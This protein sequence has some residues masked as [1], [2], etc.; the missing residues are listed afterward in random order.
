MNEVSETTDLPAGT[1]TPEF[2]AKVD[3]IVEKARAKTTDLPDPD[4]QKCRGG[5]CDWCHNT[6]RSHVLMTA[7]DAN[8]LDAVVRLLAIEDDCLTP[9]EAVQAM[10]DE[11]TDLREQIA[12][13]RRVVG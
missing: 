2:E 5:G 10:I 4:C 1:S 7:Q 3:A 11:L 12:F 8:D 13:V 6:G 9:A